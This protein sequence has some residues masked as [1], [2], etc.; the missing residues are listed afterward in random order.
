MPVYQCKCV[1]CG[2]CKEVY[3]PLDEYNNLPYHCGEQMERVFTPLHVI[4]DIKPYQSP[5]DGKW[6]TSR[7]QHRNSMKE[8]G[9][10]EVGNEKLTRP[11][12]KKYQA[13]DLKKEI[14]TTLNKFGIT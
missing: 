7:K 9:V 13:G 4:E 2:E 3:L 10:I 11:M 14:N 5:L 6:V 8:H 12:Q 1:K